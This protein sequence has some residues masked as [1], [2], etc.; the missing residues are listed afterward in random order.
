MHAAVG[1][2]DVEI[3]WED[4]A[5]ASLAIRCPVPTLQLVA[6]HQ[7]VG[8]WLPVVETQRLAGVQEPADRQLD[9]AVLQDDRTEAI[10][11]RLEKK[12][13]DTLLEMQ[14]KERDKYSKLF[15]NFGDALVELEK[16]PKATP[17]L[18]A[19]DR[20]MFANDLAILQLAVLLSRELD[21]VPFST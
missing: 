17:P 9:Q 6:K 11:Q 3:E 20:C 10:E 5:A 1:E 7:D 13:R 2:L 12:I 21:S 15:S 8:Q 4:A 14:E 16:L 19:A 18:V